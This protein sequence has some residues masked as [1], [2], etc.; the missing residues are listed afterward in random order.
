MEDKRF[1]LLAAACITGFLGDAGLQ[2]MVARGFGGPTGWGLKPYFA[3]HGAVESLFIAGGMLS[4]F[5]ILYLY[6][7]PPTVQDLALYGVLLDLVFRRL[8]I[9][10]SLAGYY[11][12]LNYFWSAFWGAVPMLMPYGLTVLSAI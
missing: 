2:F 11:A 7:L 1:E 10:P 9:F 3:Q 8:S 4:L 12:H 6:V 5:Y